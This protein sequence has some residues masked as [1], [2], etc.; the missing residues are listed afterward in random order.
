[1]SQSSRV[2]IQLV[3]ITRSTRISHLLPSVHFRKSLI[4]QPAR[5]TIAGRTASDRRISGPR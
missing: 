1:L 5:G 2:E 4:G 3:D